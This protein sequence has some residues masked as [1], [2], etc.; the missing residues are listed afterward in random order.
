MET[1]VHSEM[2]KIK[3]NTDVYKRQLAEFLTMKLRNFI[4]LHTKQQ[5]VSYI[6]YKVYKCECTE[7]CIQRKKC[8]YNEFSFEC[9]VYRT[10]CN[11]ITS[12]GQ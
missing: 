4:P 12:I 6:S 8:V 11:T 2:A 7:L 5:C 1:V 9:T 3:A 10:M